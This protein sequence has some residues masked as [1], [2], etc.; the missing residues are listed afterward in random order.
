[1]SSLYEKIKKIEALILGTTIEGE[2]QAAIAAKNRLLEQVPDVLPQHVAAM[3]YTLHTQDHWHKQLIRAL[4]SKYGLETYRYHRQKYTT[5]MVRV[6]ER[7][8]NEV[9]WPEYQQYSKHL[10]ALVNEITS[11][12]INSIHHVEGEEK[13]ISGQLGE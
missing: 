5:V 9:L 2:R 6:N 12:L 10:E 3:E 8:L 11:D 7:F 4:C 13:I 1:M